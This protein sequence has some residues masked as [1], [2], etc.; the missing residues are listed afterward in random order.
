MFGGC[1]GNVWV[2][3]GDVWELFGSRSDAGMDA[4]KRSSTL[5]SGSF[6]GRLGVVGDVLEKIHDFVRRAACP[7]LLLSRHL[8]N[9]GNECGRT[10]RRAADTQIGCSISSS[11]TIASSRY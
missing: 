4:P 3:L 1:L 5:A 11:A 7:A 9:Q 8:A 10:A 6:G 2:S